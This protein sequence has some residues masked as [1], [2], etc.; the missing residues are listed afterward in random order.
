MCSLRQTKNQKGLVMKILN[1]TDSKVVNME[2]DFTEEEC[3]MLVKYADDNMPDERLDE[4]K[5]EWA[6]IEILKAQIAK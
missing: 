4:L 1:E 5:I 3:Q 6:F 2:C